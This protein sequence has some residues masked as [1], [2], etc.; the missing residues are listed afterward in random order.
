[1]REH[2]RGPTA[3]RRKVRKGTRS[4][5][6]CKR[7]K[8]RCGFALSSDETCVPCRR[9]GSICVSQEVPEEMAQLTNKREQGER[10]ERM[11]LLLKQLGVDVSVHGNLDPPKHQR[12][13]SE[14]RTS[15][16]PLPT[17]SLSNSTPTPSLASSAHSPGF[18]FSE[19]L[20]L[21]HCQDGPSSR[22]LAQKADLSDSMRWDDSWTE[23]LT[24]VSRAL[25]A[26]LPTPKDVQI[27]CGTYKDSVVFGHQILM[28]SYRE[29]EAG[30][31]ETAS[32]LAQIPGIETHPVLLARW[33]LVFSLFLQ[34]TLPL[35]S[36][37]LSEDP[38]V[39]MNRLKD[40][41][42]CLVATNEELFGTV[43]SLECILL[44]AQFEKVRGQFRRAWLAVRRAMTAAQLMN[45]H[46]PHN[47]SIKTLDPNC[48]TSPRLL[49]FRI[50]YMDRFICLMLGLPAASL[51]FD[52]TVDMINDTP[53]GQLE[54]THTIATKQI[55]ERNEM[56]PI[57]DDYAMTEA[58]DAE[59][60][61]AAEKL[62]PQFWQPLDWTRYEKHDVH[63]FW[64]VARMS[65]QV[66]HFNLLNHLHLPYL[67]HFN[68]ERYAPSK[69]TCAH[70]SR[71]ILTR[72]M[73]FRGFHLESACCRIGDFF[74]L[75][76]GLT[77]CLAHL[78]NHHSTKPLT[79]LRHQ[80]VGD[81][82]MIEQIIKTMEQVAVNT[83]D[84]LARES[85]DLLQRLL[86]VEADAAKGQ[87]YSAR[88]Y[89]RDEHPQENEGSVLSIYIPYFGILKISREG[90]ISMEST[91]HPVPPSRPNMSLL[92]PREDRLPESNHNPLV[93]MGQ[94]PNH[95]TAAFP[96][97]SPEDL[98]Q[99]SEADSLQRAA[100]MYSLGP[101][102]PQQQ[103][104]PWPTA[105][106]D[107]WAFQGVDAAFFD[108][109][110]R[111]VNETTG[112]L[113]SPNDSHG[114]LDTVS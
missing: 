1:M 68:D 33:M 53:T 2:D 37:S 107:D 94:M 99:V 77:L 27:L 3:R 22:A 93:G 30:P 45:L 8:V 104:F 92:Q 55:L 20:T 82:S 61:A 66:N 97:A 46:R 48:T 71:E 19:P 76:A 5:W 17:P 39:V 9:R 15:T 78:G 29:L 108:S 67:L 102:L 113:P 52:M 90:A 95:A 58:I 111:G 79:A 56:D 25:H 7:R 57:V 63:I 75:R 84:P 41:A 44:E 106:V 103:L 74:A 83:N 49:W 12:L 60:L 16:R 28:R 73:G 100:G 88:T 51:G 36:S 91:T 96:G 112:F 6:E 86:H 13:Q 10:I 69:T 24:K 38:R 35:E 98:V 14:S 59:L 81:R 18:H 50:V 40:T 110:M 87:V 26:A 85:A 42:S 62:P 34:Q 23:K 54:R 80:R 101:Y 47:L 109:L 105:G 70:S 43:E 4:C 32:K 11:E 31:M 72:W 21:V 114:G 64:Q 89:Q 65:N